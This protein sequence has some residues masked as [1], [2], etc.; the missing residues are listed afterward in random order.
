MLA[1]TTH[2]KIFRSHINYF[3]NKFKIL[4]PTWNREFE[5]ADVSYFISGNQSCFEYILKQ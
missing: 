3:K 1:F 5:L 2:G 4:A